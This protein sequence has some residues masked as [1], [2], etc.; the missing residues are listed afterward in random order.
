MIRDFIFVDDDYIN[1]FLNLEITKEVY[2]EAKSYSFT[3]PEEALKY[4]ENDYI[5]ETATITVLF[6]DINMPLMDGWQF[7]AAFDLFDDSLK[8]KFNIYILSSS[9]DGKD[10]GYGKSGKQ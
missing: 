9:V 7:L 6:L 8:S 5:N 3:D 4:I 10:M 2:K 1:N